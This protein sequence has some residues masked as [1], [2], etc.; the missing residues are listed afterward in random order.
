MTRPADIHLIRNERFQVPRVNI[1]SWVVRNLGADQCHCFDRRY[2]AINH[3]AFRD[4]SQ[5]SSFG[6]HLENPDCHRGTLAL[7]SPMMHIIFVRPERLMIPV[8]DG[9]GSELLAFQ[10]PTSVC[11]RH[12]SAR[13]DSDDDRHLRAAANVSPPTPPK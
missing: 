6:K 5:S 12:R 8:S 13:G 2:L 4:A 7:L 3:S 9:G 1:P 10:V 11:C